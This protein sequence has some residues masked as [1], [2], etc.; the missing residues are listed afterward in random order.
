MDGLK[1]LVIAET[2]IVVQ[3]VLQRDGS[4]IAEAAASILEFAAQETI[5]LLIPAFSLLEAAATFR[6]AEKRRNRMAAE[7][8]AEERELARSPITERAAQDL[9]AF[10]SSLTSI[11][12]EETIRY[13]TLLEASLHTYGILDLNAGVL[14]EALA[15]ASDLD[16]TLQDSVVFA[17][18]LQAL[19]QR[20]SQGEL[21]F[22]LTQNSR[23]FDTREV[24]KRLSEADAE[25]V[26]DYRSGVARLRRVIDL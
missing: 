11:A 4:E 18:C 19:R 8:E 24:K 20:P 22:F 13:S 25:L 12:R 15:S 2:N 26:T 16:L 10:R 9:R 1:P 7:L 23:D 17:S 6:A 14:A 3:N 5:T 21:R